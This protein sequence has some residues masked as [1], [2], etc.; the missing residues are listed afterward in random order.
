MRSYSAALRARQ[1]VLWV[2]PTAS[3]SAIKRTRLGAE[4]RARTT[5]AGRRRAAPTGTS[6]AL[7]CGKQARGRVAWTNAPSRRCGIPMRT[8][9]ENLFSADGP[10]V[11]QLQQLPIERRDLLGAVVIRPVRPNAGH[12]ECERRREPHSS[13]VEPCHPN[14]EHQHADSAED[15][16]PGTPPT[17]NEPDDCQNRWHQEE[18]VDPRMR[19]E[20]RPNGDGD[21]AGTYAF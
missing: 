16:A 6:G 14:D 21:S 7:A 13:G 1:P 11:V 8:I 12:Q 9:R 2:L 19:P 10:V 20:E 4:Q 15:Q 5:A 17:R 3:E 18:Q